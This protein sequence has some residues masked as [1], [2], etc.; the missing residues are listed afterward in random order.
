MRSLMFML[1]IPLLAL[2]MV[3]VSKVHEPPTALAVTDITA[4]PVD[5]IMQSAKLVR[6]VP[7]QWPD[8]AKDLKITGI[9][10][11]SAEIAENGS[12]RSVEALSGHPLLVDAAVD[13]VRKWVYRPTE[14]NG[15]RLRV[16]T[17]VYVYVGPTQGGKVAPAAPP[18]IQ[19]T[20]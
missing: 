13:A 16:Q 1:L 7:P 11:L 4:I 6:R 2:W 17:T 3:E 19:H 8:E 14:L 5:P 10:K 12:I 20:T 18:V 9:V 15:Q